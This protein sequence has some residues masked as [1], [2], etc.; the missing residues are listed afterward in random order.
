VILVLLF[1]V[2]GV[3]FAL[4]TF[5]VS[6]PVDLVALGLLVVTVAIVI[7]VNAPRIR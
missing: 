6:A 4:A 1:I 7:G 3:L 5:K 2:A